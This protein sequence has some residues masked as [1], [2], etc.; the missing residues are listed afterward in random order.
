MGGIL[1]RFGHVPFCEQNGQIAGNCEKSPERYCLMETILVPVDGATN[2]KLEILDF[3]TLVT[4]SDQETAAPVEEAGGLEYN[5]TARQFSWYDSVLRRLPR[6]V[7]NVKVIAP[8]ARG[9]SGG[10][11]GA[12][13]TL[14]EVPGRGLTLSYTQN[15]PVRVEEAFS[16]LAGSDRDF[17]LETGSIRDFP[18]SLTLLK[19]FLFEEIERPGLVASAKYFAT[20]GALLSGHFLEDNYLEAVRKAG[21]EHSYWMCHSGTRNINRPPGTP[22][23]LAKKV[24]SFARLVPE[25]TRTVYQ[26][27]GTMPESQASALGLTG[28]LTVIPGGHDTCLSHIPILSTFYR[29]FPEKSGGPVIQVD[30]GSWTVV[31]LIGGPAL[32]PPDGHK[33]DIL[34]QGTVDGYPVVT[35]RYGGGNDFRFIRQMVEKRGMRFEASLDEKLLQMILDQADCFVLPNVNPINRHTGPFP[36]WKGKIIN[37]PAFLKI[38]GK[39]FIIT[40]LCTAIITAG[41]IEDL[42]AEGNV[43]VVTTAGGSK[44]PYFGRLLAALSGRHVYALFDREGRALSETTTLGA[45]ITGKAACLGIHPYQVDISGLGVI[46]KKLEPFRDS[47]KKKLCRYRERFMEELTKAGV[48]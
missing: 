1:C 2:I 40:N 48:P 32:L 16:E 45:A 9:A 25:R 22:S 6:G 20:Y 15:Y 24:K 46:Y 8:A 13:N 30:A 36:D 11:V 28:D 21:N 35:A 7:K 18:G 43:P 42:G 44:D 12:D 10:L 19:R 33:R 41:R 29:A 37:E 5:A 4:L 14:I 39:A 3:D 23:S 26:P 38:P 27:L 47:I 31:S 34:V 17:F